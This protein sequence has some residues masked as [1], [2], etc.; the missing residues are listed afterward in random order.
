MDFCEYCGEASGEQAVICS[1]CQK[2]LRNSEETLLVLEE[3]PIHQPTSNT[4]LP[5]TEPLQQSLASYAAQILEQ[6]Q[7]LALLRLDMQEQLKQQRLALEE[8]LREQERRFTGDLAK[9]KDKEILPEKHRLTSWQKRGMAIFLVVA[10][11]AFLGNLALITLYSQL[12]HRT[13]GLVLLSTILVVFGG[14]YLAYDVLEGEQGPLV[15]LTAYVTY[16]LIGVVGAS[17]ASAIFMFQDISIVSLS[18]RLQNI[19]IDPTAIVGPRGAPLLTLFTRGA[20]FCLFWGALVG[21][22]GNLLAKKYEQS[23]YEQSQL[24]WIKSVLFELLSCFGFWWLF[25]SMFIPTFILPFVHDRIV[26]PLFAPTLA[27][28]PTFVS[29][30]FVR[31]YRDLVASKLFRIKKDA[32]IRYWTIFIPSTVALFALG[33]FILFLTF[34]MVWGGE[35]IPIEGTAAVAFGFVLSGALSATFAPF[36][37]NW[38]E[39]LDKRSLGSIGLALVTLGALIGIV[40]A[41]LDF[42]F[43]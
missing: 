27:I 22:A 24:A 10:T 15:G 7:M 3:T 37:I 4:P 33:P 40:P 12:N 25:F 31:V 20:L 21:I 6:Q 5:S 30:A 1:H 35:N 36:T 14:F 19:N 26:V 28:I 17:I 11:L 43:K 16:A 9:K 38:A 34:Q 13:D 29:F 41:L 42:A 32:P 23:K 39:N 8:Q 18:S 2:P